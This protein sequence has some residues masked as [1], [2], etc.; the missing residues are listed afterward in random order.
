MKTVYATI[1]SLVI[2]GTQALASGGGGEGEGLS[3]MATFFIAF[4][5]LIVMFQFVPGV[6]LFIGMLRGLF[7]STQKKATEAVAG[8]GETRQ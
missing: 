2:T 1:L 8:N 3:L 7:S 4:G 6:M 5:V